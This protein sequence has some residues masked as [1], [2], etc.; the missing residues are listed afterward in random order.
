MKYY[1][2]RHIRLDKNEPFYIG[3]GTKSELDIKYNIFK[4]A[5]SIFGR[6]GHWQNIVNKTN[7]T[8]QIMY[9]SNC[10]EEII[11]KEKEFIKLYGRRDLGL[12]TLV[13]MTDGGEGTGR[14]NE[15]N[16]KKI[17]ILDKSLNLV[18]SVKN[19]KEASHY[20]YHK[21]D[22]HKQIITNCKFGFRFFT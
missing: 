18:Q 6:N 20:I 19:S 17:L 14:K 10:K 8:I 9:E 16:F 11:E 21:E 22:K 15:H 5:S 3:I 12:G 7:Y 13:N 1:L 2:Y 4:R